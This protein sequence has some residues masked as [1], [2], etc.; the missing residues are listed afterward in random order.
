MPPAGYP[1]GSICW[2]IMQHSMTNLRYV[3]DDSHAGRMCREGNQYPFCSYTD[4]TVCRYNDRRGSCIYSNSSSIAAFCICRDDSGMLPTSITTG[5]SSPSN[6]AKIDGTT[7][8]TSQGATNGDF[9]GFT[10][11][12]CQTTTSHPSTTTSNGHHSIAPD[13]STVAHGQPTTSADGQGN[14]GQ[15]G[16]VGIAVGAAVAFIILL[17]ILVVIFLCR[18]WKLK[19]VRRKP[20]NQVDESAS[21]EM[22]RRASNRAQLPEPLVINNLEY[23]YAYDHWPV[24]PPNAATVDPSPVTRAGAQVDGQ[25]SVRYVTNGPGSSSTETWPTTEA[26]DVHPY[27]TPGRQAGYEEVEIEHDEGSATEVAHSSPGQS[28]TEEDDH[29]YFQVY[30]TRESPR[31]HNRETPGYEE[32]G[33]TGT[34]AQD[35]AA[36]SPYQQLNIATMERAVYQ[37]LK[38]KADDDLTGEENASGPY[39]HLDRATMESAV[40]QGLKD[41]ADDD[42]TG[43]EN[44]SSPYQHLNRATLK[45]FNEGGRQKDTGDFE[46]LK[47]KSDYDVLWP[48]GDNSTE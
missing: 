32:V 45:R 36:S 44:A 30:P 1:D 31:S 27:F 4:A 28:L 14:A 5:Y 6:C 35:N 11:G 3:C 24:R 9:L 46:H 48:N 19:V 33:V 15:V 26:A 12:P 13:Q 38:D 10:S 16:V 21:V 18:S 20:S 39:Q 40:Y 41:K 42:L 37:G 34:D 22:G 25:G 17:V 7:Q 29:A 23:S 8:A 47:G 43:E 2:S